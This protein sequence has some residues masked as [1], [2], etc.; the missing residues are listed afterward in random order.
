MQQDPT[1]VTDLIDRLIVP[2]SF[3]FSDILSIQPSI[4]FHAGLTSPSPPINL[5]TLR[6]LEKAKFCLSDAGIVASQQE[7][8]RSLVELWLSTEQTIVAQR[9]GDLLSGLL[10]HGGTGRSADR[11]D[12]LLDENLMWRRVFRDKDIYGSLFS[13]CSLTTAGQNGQPS[14]R[15]KTVA[16]GRLLD[17]LLRVRG[18]PTRTSQIPEIEHRYGA[19]DGGL[20]EFAIVQMIDHKNDDL[21]LSTLLNFCTNFIRHDPRQNDSD[22]SPALEFVKKRG[23]HDLCLSYY[24]ESP[25][26]HPSWVLGGSAQ[27]LSAYCSSYRKDF[28]DDSVLPGQ[29]LEILRNRLSSIS[30]GAWLSG[31]MPMNELSVMSHLPRTMLLPHGDKSPMLLVPPHSSNPIIFHTLSSIL[32]CSLEHTHEDQ[33]AARVLYFIYLEEHPDFWS[34]VIKAADTVAILDAALAANHLIASIIAT[35]WQALPTTPTSAQY[36]LPTEGWLSRK[37][38]YGEPLPQSGLEAI[39]STSVADKV[40]PYI[41]KPAQTFGD[42]VGGG[43]GDVESAAWKVA[44]AK[45][46]VLKQFHEKIKLMGSSPDVQAMNT[47]VGQRLAQGPMGGSSQV[48]GRIG[49][50][51]R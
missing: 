18:D 30:H 34:L 20:L 51:E 47:A 35:C 37:Y 17:F 6:L 21:M 22:A 16:Q 13:I 39:M 4:N 32:N 40:L 19:T 45:H 8:V 11:V 26:S 2:Q 7:T 33:A 49:T 43:R 25:T 28:F 46:E 5:I 42:A 41:M 29:I 12:T 44:V 50:M 38:N 3:T 24:L 10:L 31:R 14:I 1:P 9:A 15:Q 48:G 27:Y 23:I 36:G